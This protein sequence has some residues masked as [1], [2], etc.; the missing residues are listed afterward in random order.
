MLRPIRCLTSWRARLDVTAPRPPRRESVAVHV[1]SKRK[2]VVAGKPTAVET[3]LAAT[4]P[5]AS[6]ATSAQEHPLSALSI[7][8]GPQ[9]R[10][11]VDDT[12]AL[13]TWPACI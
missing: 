1:A 9:R 13:S 12:F 2:A 8:H 4:P 5:A 6:L 3:V 7:G 11:A 10:G